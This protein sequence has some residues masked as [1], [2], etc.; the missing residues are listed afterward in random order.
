MTKTILKEAAQETTGLWITD[1]SP[2]N[3]VDR[4]AP[5]SWHPFLR[6]IRL[7]RPIGTWLLLFPCWW[8]VLLASINSSAG[9]LT[10]IIWLLIL[11]T[12]GAI[13]MRGAGCAYN[14]F[15]DRDFDA[16]ISRTANRPI[17]S[18]QITPL[19]ALLV[20]ALLSAIG[21]IVLLQLN[22]FSIYL[23]AGSILLVLTYPF[24]KRH[25][26]WPQLFLGLTFNWG[27]LVGWSAVQGSLSLPP[28]T[29][30]LGAVLWTVGYDT[31]YAH[32]DAEEDLALNIK[33][34]AL[35]FGENSPKWVGAF[36]CGALMMWA[37]TG[38]LVKANIAFY[39]FL[40]MVG[41]QLFW[42]VMTY[43][44]KKPETCLRCFRS[45]IYVGLMMFMGLLTHF[46]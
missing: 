30:Y 19:Q 6:L 15:V 10:S 34:T 41:S 43:N 33:S 45:N 39:V 9:D 18:G 20:V 27:A 23:G 28:L 5:K 26:F 13:S 46:L 3:W 11:F 40:T 37:L 25:T 29:L 24:M 16:K 14:D 2:H 12:I 42:Q 21:L 36:Y 38:M 32:Q 44:E 7:D 35:R 4:Y 17:A 31:I 8:S 22:Y 1:A